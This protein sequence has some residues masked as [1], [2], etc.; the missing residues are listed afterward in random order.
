MKVVAM[1]FDIQ[2]PVAQ[3]YPN[4]E[5]H[6]PFH[7]FSSNFPEVFLVKDL[8]NWIITFWIIFFLARLRRSKKRMTIFRAPYGIFFYNPQ[9]GKPRPAKIPSNIF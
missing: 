7:Q 5:K 4:L 9:Q 8:T 3:N 1:Y 2:V 6:P